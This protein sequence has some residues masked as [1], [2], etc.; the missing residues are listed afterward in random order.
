MPASDFGMLQRCGM[1]GV[2][3]ILAKSVRDANRWVHI[4]PRT[5]VWSMVD[6]RRCYRASVARVQ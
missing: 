5:W 2:G 1:P 3:V 4:Q 6:V